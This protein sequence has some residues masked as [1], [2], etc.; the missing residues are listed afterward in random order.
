MNTNLIGSIDHV[1]AP[2]PIIVCTSAETPTMEKY[3]C[4]GIHYEGITCTIF[5]DY[6]A[7]PNF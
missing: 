6:Q 5:Y 2:F 4:K 7:T 3:Q 1:P